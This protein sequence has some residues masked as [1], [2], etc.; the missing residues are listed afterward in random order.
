MSNIVPN[1][2]SLVILSVRLP[3]CH[4]ATIN[5]AAPADSYLEATTPPIVVLVANFTVST[6]SAIDSVTGNP[7]SV[8]QKLLKDGQLFILRNG[9]TFNAQGARVE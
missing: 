5:D 1:Y 3:I 7:S 4:K 2:N 9:K 8:T 6:P